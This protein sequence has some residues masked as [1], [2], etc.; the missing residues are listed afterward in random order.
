[1]YPIVLAIHN[2]VRWVVVI[3]G[4]IA[5]VRGL[6]GWLGKREWSSTDRTLGMVFTSAIDIQ[7]LL[8]LFLYVFLSPITKSMFQNLSQA[9]SNPGMRFFGLEHAFFMILAV[10]LAHVGSA[11]SKRASETTAKHRAAAIWFG[12][13]LIVVLLGMPWMRPLLPAF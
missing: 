4:I 6:I 7:L 5:V 2:I 3:V 13:A 8:G 12:L 1:M 11:L 9:M 10:V